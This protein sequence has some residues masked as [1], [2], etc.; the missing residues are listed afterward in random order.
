MATYIVACR[1]SIYCQFETSFLQKKVKLK[2]PNKSIILNFRQTEN[3]G[4]VVNTFFRTSIKT[5]SLN[6]GLSLI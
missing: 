5:N 1:Y 4:D 6:E 2:I 3:A